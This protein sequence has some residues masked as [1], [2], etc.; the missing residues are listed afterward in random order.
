MTTKKQTTNT[1][2]ATAESS[3][4]L[5]V[6]IDVDELVRLANDDAQRTDVRQDDLNMPWL[7]LIQAMSTVI[8][9]DN[10][11]A[12]DGM[13]YNSGTGKL[14]DIRTEPLAF[15]PVHY[16][17]EYVE[18]LPKRGKCA[19]LGKYHRDDP[20]VVAAEKANVRNGHG[21]LCADP[22]NPAGN[23]LVKTAYWSVI[24]EGKPGVLAL[25]S[26]SLKASS[27]LLSLINAKTFKSGD[28]E[29]VYP[30]YFFEYKLRSVPDKND[31]GDFFN[32]KIEDG[33]A[34]TDLSLIKKCKAFAEIADQFTINEE[35]ESKGDTQIVDTTEGAV[36]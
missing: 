28:L 15:I 18:W 4:A 32:F 7:K 20:K 8:K 5:A 14:Y 16:K 1:E 36:I 33:E 21:Q 6:N 26:T 31:K 35:E 24:I 25:K 30:K 10:P 19:L 27:D 9:A 12:E 13:L 23:T 2:V 34:I 3:H 17:V 22:S 11:G 29:M